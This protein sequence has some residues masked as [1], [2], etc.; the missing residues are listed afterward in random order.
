LSSQRGTL[1]ELVPDGKALFAEFGYESLP[2]A[3]IGYAIAGFP[4]G[5]DAPALLDQVK[6]ILTTE[7]TN[8]VLADLVEAAKRREISSAEFQK[9]SVEGLAMAW[10]QAVAVEGRQ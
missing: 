6:Q 8:G 10:S 2:K 1:Y 9:N 3:G 5:A 4:A 7:T